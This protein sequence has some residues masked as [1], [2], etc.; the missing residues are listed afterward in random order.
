MKKA[1]VVTSVVAASAAFGFWKYLA[2]EESED[3]D[4]HEE[5]VDGSEGVREPAEVYED[6]RGVVAAAGNGEEVP[7][8][9][10]RLE[11]V[12]GARLNSEAPKKNARGRYRSVS[13]DAAGRR[14]DEN[15]ESNEEG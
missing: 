4:D 1:V 5:E 7:D 3:E 14:A 15:I 13:H 11:P 12:N 2:Q 10:R 8:W 6:T 9:L